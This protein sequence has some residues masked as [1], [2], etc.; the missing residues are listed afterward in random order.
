[1]SLSISMYES[2]LFHEIYITVSSGLGRRRFAKKAAE[3][4]HWSNCWKPKSLPLFAHVYTV[5][6]GTWFLTNH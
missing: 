2:W 3:K 4:L 6:A 5:M 1:M